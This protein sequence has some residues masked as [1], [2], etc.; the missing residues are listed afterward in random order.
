MI[1]CNARGSFGRSNIWHGSAKE[2]GVTEG[3]LGV[4]IAPGRYTSKGVGV[5][6]EEL[7]AALG[8][9]LER[10]KAFLA[11]ETQPVSRAVPTTAHRD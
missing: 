5:N 4:Q 3:E 2:I 10:L 8:V 1:C 9:K 6:V 11:A 7:E